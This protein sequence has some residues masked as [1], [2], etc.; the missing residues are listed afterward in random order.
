MKWQ[1]KVTSALVF[2]LSF[3]FF[4]N[5]LPL[6]ESQTKPVL[7]TVTKTKTRTAT[8]SF[9]KTAV[10]TLTITQSPT[11]TVTP[12]LTP[13]QRKQIT[14]FDRTNLGNGQSI[15]SDVIDVREYSSASI[16]LKSHVSPW[17][18]ATCYYL[19]EGYDSQDRYTG[20]TLTVTSGSGGF[21]EAYKSITL[22][23]PYLICEVKNNT[24]GSNFSLWLYLI[25]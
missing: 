17:N 23:G 22:T 20:E 9:T 1:I 16:F 25:P 5:T 13:V 12:S 2:I 10:P 19:P 21:E 18:T 24:S 8:V 3:S 6:A 15:S 11:I 14:V 4:G 7:P